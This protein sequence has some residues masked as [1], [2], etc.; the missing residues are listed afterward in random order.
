MRVIWCC[1]TKTLES[2][3]CKN[4]KTAY[5]EPLWTLFTWRHQNKA[6]CCEVAHDCWDR[7]TSENAYI[8]EQTNKA[9]L[10]I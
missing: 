4:S 6:F 10:E 2:L 7:K 5:T 3:E 8:T 1:C 9:Y